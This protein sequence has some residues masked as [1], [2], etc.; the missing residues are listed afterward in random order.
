MDAALDAERA[1]GDP[2][3]RKVLIGKATEVI[4][5]KLPSLFTSVNLNACRAGLTD[6]Y[7]YPNGLMDV[8]RAYYKDV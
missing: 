1:E 6:F 8:S 3:K 7:V 5:S 2:A 4:A